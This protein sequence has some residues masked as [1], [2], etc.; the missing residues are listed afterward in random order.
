MIVSLLRSRSVNRAEC[1]TFQQCRGKNSSVALVRIVL[2]Q[3]SLN[4]P[5]WPLP[6]LISRGHNSTKFRATFANWTAAV[7]NSRC[8]SL[9]H[10]DRSR[11]PACNTQLA[12]S[13]GPSTCPS[14]L[15]LSDFIV[16]V[17]VHVLVTVHVF[18]AQ[19]Q[20]LIVNNM[21]CSWV[22]FLCFFEVSH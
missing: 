10:L 20:A 17:I 3:R 9:A 13:T 4:T 15:N 11:S 14:M 6:D 5:R 7:C 18:R 21:Q 16:L 8:A 1:T 2:M 22:S 19:N 12:S